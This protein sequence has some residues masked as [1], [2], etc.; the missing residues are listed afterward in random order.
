[1]APT[2]YRATFKKALL[3]FIT[4]PDRSLAWLRWIMTEMMRLEA[5]RKIE[6]LAHAMRIDNISA[7]QVSEFNKELDAQ[8]ADFKTRPL[9]E[10]SLFLWIDA[11]Y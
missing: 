1:M 4:E 9:A 8:V 3:H 5:D 11:L 10:E 6:R 7:S 2:H